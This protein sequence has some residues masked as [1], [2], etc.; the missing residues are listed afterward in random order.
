M[1]ARDTVTSPDSGSTTFEPVPSTTSIAPTGSLCSSSSSS[2][3]R[4]DSPTRPATSWTVNIDAT[5]SFGSTFSRGSTAL[6]EVLRSRTS[7]L[8]T[9][10]TAYSGGPSSPEG[11]GPLDAERPQQPVRAAVEEADE[12]P[13]GSGEQPLRPDDDPSHAQLGDG[14]VLGRTA[15]L[16]I[17]VP[18][19][20]PDSSHQGELRRYEDRVRGDQQQRCAEQDPLGHEAA[21]WRLGGMGSRAPRAPRGPRSGTRCLHRSVRWCR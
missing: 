16:L 12:E 14:P 20:A 3:S 1:V 10:T 9:R 2:P 7:G 5:S 11:D 17:V 6:A 21:G 18:S 15:R 19:W 4:R 8:I 13:G